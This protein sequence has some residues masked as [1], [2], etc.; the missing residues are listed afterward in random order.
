MPGG[1]L[2]YSQI[3]LQIGSP[4]AVMAASLAA[5]KLQAV[6]CWLWTANGELRKEKVPLG[7]RTCPGCTLPRRERGRAL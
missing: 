6:L 1:S 2:A 4:K 5:A 3:E 7:E